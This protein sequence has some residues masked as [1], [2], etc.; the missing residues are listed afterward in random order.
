MTRDELKALYEAAV[1]AERRAT[2]SWAINATTRSFDSDL[3]YQM[4][5]AMHVKAKAAYDE[6]VRRFLQQADAA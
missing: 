1:E 2:V 6:G 5:W 4:A 3:S